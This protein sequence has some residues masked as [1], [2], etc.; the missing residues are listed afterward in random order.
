MDFWFV[1]VSALLIF[2][3]DSVKSENNNSTTSNSTI[4]TTVPTTQPCPTLKP[5]SELGFFVMEWGPNCT[6]SVVLKVGTR[7]NKAVC[8]KSKS[9]V[10]HLLSG[11]CEQNEGM[12]RKGERD[13]WKKSKRS[14]DFRKRSE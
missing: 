9:R 10:F 1:A 3:V 12:Q 4:T 2:T 11:V 5:M 14:R 6:G 13:N 7:A 8:F